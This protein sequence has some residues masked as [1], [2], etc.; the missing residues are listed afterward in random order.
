MTIDIVNIKSHLKVQHH[1]CGCVYRTTKK[2]RQMKTA[3]ITVLLYYYFAGI[4]THTFS[5]NTNAVIIAIVAKTRCKSHY[6]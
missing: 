5:I 6:L 3:P 1:A 2:S 4:P